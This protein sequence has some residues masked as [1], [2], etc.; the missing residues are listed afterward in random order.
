LVVLLLYT[1]TFKTIAPTAHLHLSGSHE[2]HSNK[3]T[4]FG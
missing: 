1:T 4:Y 3:D 2:I